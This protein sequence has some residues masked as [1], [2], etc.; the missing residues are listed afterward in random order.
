MVF[1]QMECLLQKEVF[2]FE[3]KKLI[4]LNACHM[5]LLFENHLLQ[6]MV[7]EQKEFL[8]QR[9]FSSLK[10]V[11]NVERLPYVYF[12]KYI[13]FKSRIVQLAEFYD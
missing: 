4:M 10:K 11:N 3:K 1:E 7:F 2:E 13:L 6:Q 12:L 8:L 5:F 9:R